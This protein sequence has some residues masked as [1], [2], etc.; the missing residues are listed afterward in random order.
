M[1]SSFFFWMIDI[2]K[3]VHAWVKYNFWSMSLQGEELLDTEFTT[4]FGIVK[5]D[6]G[7]NSPW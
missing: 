3:S 4:V 7:P 6:A 2:L 5:E 1:L